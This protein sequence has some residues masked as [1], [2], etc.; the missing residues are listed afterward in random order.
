MISSVA[1]DQALCVEVCNIREAISFDYFEV[2]IMHVISPR[3][4]LRVNKFD[5]CGFIA[6]VKVQIENYF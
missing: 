1:L 2:K 3:C 4:D 6:S 5:F